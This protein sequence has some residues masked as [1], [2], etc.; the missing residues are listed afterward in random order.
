MVDDFRRS[1]GGGPAGGAGD[2]AFVTR[3]KDLLRVLVYVVGGLVALS[4]ALAA[5]YLLW[6]WTGDGLKYIAGFLAALALLLAAGFIGYPLVKLGHVFA[7]LSESVR[8]LTDQTLPVLDGLGGT[9][10]AANQE[11]GKLAVVT[12]DVAAMS[13]H[14]RDVTGNASRVSRLV[15]DTVV[16]PFVKLSALRL[17]LTKL[18]SRRRPAVT[19]ASGRP[20][21]VAAVPG[22]VAPAGDPLVARTD[23]A[24][25]ALGVR[26]GNDRTT[27]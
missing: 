7:G 27:P 24:T 17:A 20:V 23:A 1:T 13:G 3:L 11:L 14:L 6:W 9:V 12:E 8:E 22:S 10:D 5:G 4:P 26:P 21:T 16:V 2:S 18:F 19:R 25:P 15:A